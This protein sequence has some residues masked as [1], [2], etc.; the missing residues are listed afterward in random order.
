MVRGKALTFDNGTEWLRIAEHFLLCE[1][2]V[3]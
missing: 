1:N 3:L 2:T